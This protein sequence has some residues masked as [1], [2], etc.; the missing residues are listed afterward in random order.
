MSSQSALP[1][2]EYVSTFNIPYLWIGPHCE[3]CG[4]TR[5]E[6]GSGRL[7]KEGVAFAVVE[8][9]ETDVSLQWGCVVDVEGLHV[10]WV[11]AIFVPEHACKGD[12]IIR[13]PHFFILFTAST[14]KCSKICPE[15]LTLGEYTTHAHTYAHTHTRMHACTH[16]HTHTHTHE[17]ACYLERERQTKH[18]ETERQT[19]RGRQG[20]TERTRAN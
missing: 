7:Q 9:T 4:F 14:L 20:L 13:L 17:Q 3:V 6:A 2:F 16:A 19:G 18:T 12:I 5:L 8:E 1:A 11:F 15:L 10:L